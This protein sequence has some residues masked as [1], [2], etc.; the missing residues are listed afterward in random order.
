MKKRKRRRKSRYKRGTHE[1]AKLTN[2]PA[3][4]RSGWELAYMKWLDEDVD[5]ISYEYEPFFIEYI[6]NIR[7]GKKRK[8]YPDVLVKRTS[9]TELVEIK[10]KNKLTKPIVLKKINAASQW[11]PANGMKLVVITEVELKQLGV[12]K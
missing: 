7:T 9:S 8:Y 6:S 5:V 2:G 10:P 11:A 4:Y 3:N 12:I 1:S